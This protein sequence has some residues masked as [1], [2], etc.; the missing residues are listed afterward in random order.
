MATFTFLEIIPNRYAEV[1]A[2][3]QKKIS[4]TYILSKW[5]IQDKERIGKD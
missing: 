5:G 3:F 2:L 4:T 1:I